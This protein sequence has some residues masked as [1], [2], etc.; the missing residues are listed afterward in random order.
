MLHCTGQ[1][2]SRERN[3]AARHP[4]QPSARNRAHHT[5]RSP[6]VRDALVEGSNQIV[7]LQ[8]ERRD[9]VGLARTDEVGGGAFEAREVAVGMSSERVWRFRGRDKAVE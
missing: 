4:E 3:A 5:L 9:G 2:V 6:I 8:V 1:E 7:Q